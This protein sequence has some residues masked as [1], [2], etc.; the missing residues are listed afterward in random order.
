MRS[1][2]FTLPVAFSVSRIVFRLALCA[3]LLGASSI[4]TASAAERTVLERTASVEADVKNLDFQVAEIR[5]NFTDRSGLIGATDARDR[6]E[7]GVYQYL[8]GDYA[9]AAT[10]FYILVNSRALGTPDLAR[11]SEWYLSECLFEMGNHRTAVESYRLIV[12]AGPAHPYFPDAARRVLETYSILGDNEA[13]D[14]FYTAFIVSG[15]VSTS[16]LIS[17][18]L[19]KSFYRRGEA[20]RAKAMFEAV[21]QNTPYYSRARY[22]LGVQMIREGNLAQAL[23]E[24]Q[25]AEKD[26][27]TDDEHKRVHELAQLA[28]ARLYYEAGDTAQATIWYGKVSKGSPNFADQ[29]YESAWALIRQGNDTAEARE[30]A[31][32]ATAELARSRGEREVVPDNRLTPDE[33]KIWSAAATQVTLFLEQFPQHR[34]TSSMKIDRGHLQ[35]KLQAYDEAEANYQ[36]VVS[37]YEPVVSKLIEI[38]GDKQITSLFLDELTDDKKGASEDLLPGYAEEILLSR[39]EVG[40]AA[41]A[42]GSLQHQRAELAESDQLVSMLTGTMGQGKN[43]LGNF[44]TA[45]QQ[46]EGISGSAIALQGRL[47]DA[48]LLVVRSAVPGRRS[49]IAA[50]QKRCDNAYAD[51][52]AGS[53]I[54]ASVVKTL[55]ELR[56]T[57]RGFRGEVVD[58]TPLLAIDKLWTT[59]ET[60]ND[61]VAETQGLLIASEAREMG[62]VQ[63]KLTATTARVAELHAD[64]ANQTVKVDG[65]AQQTVQSGVRAVAETFRED[66]LTADKGIVDVAWLRKGSTTDQ[67]E[68]LSREQSALLRSIKQQYAALRTNADMDGEK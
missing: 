11:D 16:E 14:T 54:N 60:L 21:P 26:Q 43:R 40:R 29:L 5:R 55:N 36:R 22:F 46:L 15:K 12:D 31:D 28:I 35:M 62:A 63:T 10:S 56:K 27:V 66:V 30:K 47:V 68:L 34:Y 7:E 51:A 20:G 13:F 9:N 67:M 57:L 32:L 65:L 49:E 45:R 44:V 3:C 17:Y 52:A 37:E 61:K 24:F 42:W 18:T 53:D 48:E 19:A 41:A 6:Y 59:V 39:S 2:R 25:A 38:Q 50:L 23:I 33:A 4:P 64:L 58:A 1:E 8:V